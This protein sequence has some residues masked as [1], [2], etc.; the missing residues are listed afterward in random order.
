MLVSMWSRLVCHP[1]QQ[2]TGGLSSLG[3]QSYVECGKPVPGIFLW[4]FSSTALV[5]PGCRLLCFWVT[6]AFPELRN[7]CVRAGIKGVVPLK[8]PSRKSNPKVVLFLFSW[9]STGK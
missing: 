4:A 1:S 9:V 7:I 6:A 2:C 8:V 5:N 3:P